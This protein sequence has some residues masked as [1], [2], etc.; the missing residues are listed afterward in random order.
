MGR[1]FQACFDLNILYKSK[2]FDVFY[3]EHSLYYQ[4]AIKE[5]LKTLKAEFTWKQ[6]IQY[7]WFLR[8]RHSV[9]LGNYYNG[10]PGIWDVMDRRN[11]LWNW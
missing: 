1:V 2:Y 10:Y 11:N 9:R 6:A 8:S 5:Y 7:K 4:L 3:L